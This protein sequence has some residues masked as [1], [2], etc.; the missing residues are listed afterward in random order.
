MYLW[1][2]SLDADKVVAVLGQKELPG[3]LHLGRRPREVGEEATLLLDE[4]GV[5]Q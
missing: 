2:E 4:E 5:G 3:Q 1:H